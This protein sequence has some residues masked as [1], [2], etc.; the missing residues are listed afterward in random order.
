MT[1][2]AQNRKVYLEYMRILACAMVVFNHTPGYL[3]YMHSSGVEQAVYLALTMLTRINV[4]LF[5][6]ISGALLLGRQESYAQV[7]RV[8]VFR[9]VCIIAVWSSLYCLLDA[10]KGHLTGTAYESRVPILIYRM[11]GGRIDDL[12]SYWYL[13]AYLGFLLVLPFLQS[14]IRHMSHRDLRTLVLILLACHVIYSTL[15]PMLGVVCDMRGTNPVQLSS[16]LNLAMASSKILFYPILG[17]YIENE[18]DISRVRSIH[19]L[20][21]LTIAVG[22][23]AASGWC[24]VRQYR[25]V[26]EYTQNYV[27]LADY[28]LT[29]VA[30]VLIK[31]LVSVR[32]PQLA[33][34]RLGTV[35]TVV[36]SLTLGIYL[37]G[38]VCKLFAYHS[39]QSVLEASVPQIWFSILWVVLDMCICGVAASA[40]KRIPHIRKLL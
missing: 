15:L 22:G 35:V 39:F 27:E 33:Q 28:V 34:G 40:L 31:Y 6:M 37:L 38:P 25:M 18:F 12:S 21:M 8:R 19:V 10:I 2:P 11:L 17:Y 30:Y 5:L 14:A 3:L 32:W 24:T 9:M 36:G 20:A 1:V 29:I 16:E 23:I 13:Y 26:G 4:P 7:L